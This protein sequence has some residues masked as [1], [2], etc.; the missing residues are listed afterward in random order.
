MLTDRERIAKLEA[1]L[2][3]L[4]AAIGVAG[5]LPVVVMQSALDQMVDERLLPASTRTEIFGRVRTELAAVGV[6]S[7]E[8]ARGARAAMPRY[9][10]TA[11]REQERELMRRFQRENRDLER[12]KLR[13]RPASPASDQSTGSPPAAPEPE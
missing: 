5:A 7:A 13:L 4:R 9:P 8:L 11:D 1:D 2:L 10:T 6:G 3:E 12:E